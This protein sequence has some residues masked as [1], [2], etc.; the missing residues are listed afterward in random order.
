MIPK[1]IKIKRESLGETQ[2]EFGKRFNNSAMAVSYW[3]AGTREAPYKVLYFVL[4]MKECPTC[5]GSGV[6][7][8]QSQ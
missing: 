1:A 2:E 8:S 5:K 3:E 6:V 4:G 7:A